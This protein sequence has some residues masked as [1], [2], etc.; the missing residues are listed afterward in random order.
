MGSM[1][2]NKKYGGWF[3]KAFRMGTVAGAG[4]GAG[5]GAR[6]DADETGAPAEEGADTG[7]T[8]ATVEEEGK[9]GAL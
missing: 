1:R 2:T 7:G 4:E 8:T 6:K 5:E 3:L 9:L